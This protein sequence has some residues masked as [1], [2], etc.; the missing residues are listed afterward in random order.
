MGHA[1][2]KRHPAQTATLE[3]FCRNNLGAT[4]SS[5]CTA[6]PSYAAEFREAGVSCATELEQ[7]TAEQY[8]VRS[9]MLR[10]L[11]YNQAR[12]LQSPQV[13]G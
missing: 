5:V 9:S 2:Q 6:Q 13:L 3:S 10:S 11:I 7:C 8:Y 1:N 4:A 12:A